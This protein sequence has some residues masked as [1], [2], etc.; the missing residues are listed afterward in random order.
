MAS[1]AVSDS[2]LGVFIMPMCV[3][4][5][6]HNGTWVIGRELCILKY[7]VDYLLS[8]VSTLHILAMTLDRYLAV[9]HPLKYRLLTNKHAY[10]I[11][12]LTWL[13]PVGFLVSSLLFGLEHLKYCFQIR[14]ECNLYNFSPE[15]LAAFICSF[16]I[17]FIIVYILYICILRKLGQYKKAFGKRMSHH[18]RRPSNRHV[19]LDLIGIKNLES[20]QNKMQPFQGNLTLVTREE[21][22]RP[23]IFILSS[24]S[25]STQILTSVNQSAFTKQSAP[26]R[27][28]KTF[29]TIGV[30][31]IGFTICWLPSWTLS[32][33]F[34]VRRHFVPKWFME[35]ITWFAYLNSAI[36][37]ILYCC[38][39]S[40]RIAVRE[41]LGQR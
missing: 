39:R 26:T 14:Q 35:C 9:C 36:S 41:L 1:M 12:T 17:P 8:A 28:T 10:I 13:I 27:K 2:F 40:V 29:R 6:I 33:V 34:L 3:L 18:S 38:N 25:D 22:S 11:L 23:N 4:E 24:L 37:P 15:F 16:V 21:V 19:Q 20:S 31:M 30:V 32:L 5:V 7:C